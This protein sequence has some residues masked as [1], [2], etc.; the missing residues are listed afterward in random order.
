MRSH[1]GELFSF[2]YGLCRD[3]HLAQDLVQETFL[4]AWKHLH[5]QRDH[6][7]LG[8]PPMPQHLLSVAETR[9]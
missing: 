3:K 5:T 8:A 9:V 1:A 6:H 2:A 4:R 7:G